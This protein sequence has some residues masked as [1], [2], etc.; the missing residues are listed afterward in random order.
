M[1]GT[2]FADERGEDEVFSSSS[3]AS[4][5]TSS[6]SGSFRDLSHYGEDGDEYD[7]SGSGTL[8]STMTVLPRVPVGLCS[9]EM[10]AAPTFARRPSALDACAASAPWGGAGSL[11]RDADRARMVRPGAR[12]DSK[13]ATSANSCLRLS[14]SPYL[15]L[16]L[17]R[18]S[19]SL[20]ACAPLL[21][22]ASP[23]FL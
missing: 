19:T 3:H 13:N 14:L 21:A 10:A 6:F 8:T 1:S 12:A 2:F 15:I 20:N 17:C 11:A 7:R 9:R 22:P 5:S 23:T 18:T 16:I 4:L